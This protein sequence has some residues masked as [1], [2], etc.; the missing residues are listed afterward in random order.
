MNFGLIG[1]GAWGCYH[2]EAIAQGDGTELTAIACKSKRT[3]QKAS[4]DYPEAAVYRD[5]RDLLKREDIEAVDIVLPTFLHAQVG[6]EALNAGKHVLLEKP[7]AASAEQCDRLLEAARRNEKV[8]S[9]GHEFRLST[10]WTKVKELVDQGKIGKPLY[11]MVSLFRFPYRKGSDEW[12]YDRERVGSWILEEPIHFF[13]F[14]KWINEAH[15][16]P[17]SIIAQGNAKKSTEA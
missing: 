9:I 10:Q 6:I 4:G 1:Y 12:R 15:G 3:V 7:M 14:I 11:A 8:L 2:G 13:D 17:L 16:N 5:Y